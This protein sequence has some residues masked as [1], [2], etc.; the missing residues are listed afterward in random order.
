MN[1]LSRYIFAGLIFLLSC[2]NSINS[3]K[4]AEVSTKFLLKNSQGVETTQ[5]V[6]GQDI[7]FH[8]SVEN[9]T[10]NT[11]SYINQDTS[12]LVTFEVYKKDSLIGTSVDGLAFIPVI[13]EKTLKAR[14]VS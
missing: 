6:F 13:V 2:E 3:S 10:E 1:Y 5:F 9:T 8:Y 14:G 11:Y 4:T 7:S 12:P